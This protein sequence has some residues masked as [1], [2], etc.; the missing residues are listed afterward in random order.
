M[1]QSN[2]EGWRLQHE[3]TKDPMEKPRMLHGPR[4]LSFSTAADHDCW[5]CD[6]KLFCRRDDEAVTTPLILQ[7]K[8]LLQLENL[9]L[10]NCRSATQTWAVFY[11]F[12]L[13]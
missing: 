13:R 2:I 4:M 11:L 3:Q 10:L 8:V 5:L 7:V 6:L 9:D 1:K 12:L